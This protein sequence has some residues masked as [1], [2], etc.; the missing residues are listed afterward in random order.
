[1]IKGINEIKNIR[2]F[3]NFRTG[4]P[5]EFEKLTFIYGLNTKWK[6][7]LAAILSSLRDNDS[8]TMS[9]RKSIPELEEDQT[10]K[11]Q[12]LQVR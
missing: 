10:V 3:K 2:A 12:I 6:T 5:I 1:M 11:F 4:S 8:E 9:K 7:I